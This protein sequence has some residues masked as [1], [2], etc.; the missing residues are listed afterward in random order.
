MYV[1]ELVGVQ[2][3]SIVQNSKQWHPAY[4]RMGY[5]SYRSTYSFMHLFMLLTYAISSSVEQSQV[6]ATETLPLQQMPLISL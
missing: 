2:R 6:D 3:P 1:P 4:K 5:N